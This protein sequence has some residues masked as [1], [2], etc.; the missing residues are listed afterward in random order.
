MCII[1]TH[2]HDFVP[3][4]RL[5]W[6]GRATC[7]VHLAT[8]WH[9]P[10][11]IPSTNHF[12]RHPSWWVSMAQLKETC[13]ASEPHI[14][15]RV[16]AS[17]MIRPHCVEDKSGNGCTSPIF[18]LVK[19]ISFERGDSLLPALNRHCESLAISVLEH[20]SLSSFPPTHTATRAQLHTCNNTVVWCMKVTLCG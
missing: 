15:M 4:G 18:L 5:A 8:E 19:T 11:Y 14:V 2:P 6:P 13:T 16:G 12:F 1:T 20:H 7:A 17:K 3:F 9:G 10:S